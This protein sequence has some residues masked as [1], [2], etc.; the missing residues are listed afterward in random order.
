MEIL[1]IPI[2]KVK[3][4]DF[5]PKESLEKSI[6]N[7][8]RY[9]AIGKGIEKHGMGSPIDVREVDEG[10]EIL[11][12]FHRWL[13]FKESGR[14]TIPAVSWGRISDEKAQQ[15]CIL[16]IKARVPVSVLMMAGLVK[17][18][19]SSTPLDELVDLTGYNLG[20]L[21]EDLELADFNWEQYEHEPKI[22]KDNIVPLIVNLTE[23]QRDVIIQAFKKIKE[24]QE[25][26][27]MSDGRALELICADFL[28]K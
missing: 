1:E 22:E 12:G 24:E 23:A 7:R 15:I 18:L 9:E 2:D 21:K 25:Q 8:E 13:Y 26:P 5:N 4:N 17:E 20:E 3:P 28:G 19:A 14:P 10:Y 27:E 16:K 6:V 11:D